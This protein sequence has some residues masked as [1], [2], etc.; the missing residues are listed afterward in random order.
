MRY[1]IGT[2]LYGEVAPAE[3]VLSERR[4]ER[5]RDW[6]LRTER[7]VRASRGSRRSFVPLSNVMPVGRERAASRSGATPAAESWAMVFTAS[8]EMRWTWDCSP[9]LQPTGTDKGTRPV[10]NNQERFVKCRGRRVV[11][12]EAATRLPPARRLLTPFIQRILPRPVLSRQ[13]HVG[14]SS[15]SLIPRRCSRDCPPGDWQRQAWGTKDV[16]PWWRVRPYLVHRPPSSHASVTQPGG[17]KQQQDE[18]PGQ[19]LSQASPL[20]S[21]LIPLPSPASAGKQASRTVEEVTGL[22]DS[23]LTFTCTGHSRVDAYRSGRC[24]HECIDGTE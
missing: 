10:S 15:S 2:P 20:P 1:S 3:P 11:V 19:Q 5:E 8:Y 22:R 24:Q 16:L 17:G 18:C 7:P 9:E 21:D 13:K 23:Y 6:L 4:R 12:T 14:S